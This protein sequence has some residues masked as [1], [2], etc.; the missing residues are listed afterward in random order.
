MGRALI[1]FHLH[2]DTM[3]VLS[4][5]KS[6]CSLCFFKP[7]RYI[8]KTD[9][10]NLGLAIVCKVVLEMALPISWIL[11]TPSLLLIEQSLPHFPWLT[12]MP[13]ALELLLRMFFI[14][15]CFSHT[16]FQTFLFLQKACL[17]Y[18]FVSKS[19]NLLWFWTCF[20]F[21]YSMISLWNH[22]LFLILFL[23]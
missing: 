10:K 5:Y 4:E 13:S 2:H 21:F 7:T 3:T 16:S 19:P 9:G 17:I 1:S 8:R 23:F 15:N 18:R 11:I 14:Y 12:C 22:D 6:V 20:I